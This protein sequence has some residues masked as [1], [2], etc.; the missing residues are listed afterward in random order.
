[1]RFLFCDCVFSIHF[2]HSGFRAMELADHTF[3]V[4]GGASGLGA[5][6]CRRFAAAGANVVIA[7]VDEQA[8]AELARELG[9][10]GRSCPTDVTSEIDVQRAVEAALS[11]FGV[12]HGVVTCAG[13][14]RAGRIVGRQQPHD[15]E[16]FRTVIDINLNGTFNAVRCAAQAITAA[17]TG[18][19][20]ERGVVIMT[21]SV[22]AWDGQI[23]QTAYA[24][25][26][27]GVASMTLP[28]AREL[29]RHGIRVVS[30][31]PGIFA[32]PMMRGVS[33]EVR[34]SL[35]EQIPFPKRFGMPDEFASLAQHVVENRLLNGATLRLDG[36]VRMGPR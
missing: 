4:T 28:M 14:L 34:E 11:G 10:A 12:L 13:I 1:M 22:A 15:F 21:A 2:T 16:Q 25:S 18:A 35:E 17:P 29:G 23:G 26:K 20:G 7:D 9:A 36:A 19:D 6:C 30:I 8:G 31:A 32:T 5:A 3:L 24:A 27:G 33:A